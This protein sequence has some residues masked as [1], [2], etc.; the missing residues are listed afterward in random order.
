M[1]FD[2][3]TSLIPSIMSSGSLNSSITF[4]MTPWTDDSGKVG[5]AI[6][7]LLFTGW[8]IILFSSLNGS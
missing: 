6:V 1:A 7:I 2:L 5:I 8:F 4:S 3:P